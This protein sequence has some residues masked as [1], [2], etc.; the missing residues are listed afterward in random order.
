[1]ET[2][3]IERDDELPGLVTITLNRPEK[4]NAINARMHAEIQQ[5][6][7]D[8]ADDGDARVVIVTGAGRAFSAG[9]DLGGS[10][11]D[12]NR[13][14]LASANAER[15]PLR[16]R[17]RS[18]A[19]N[20][21]CAALEGLDQVTIGA[22]NGLAI[23]GAVVFLACLDIRVA[24]ESSWFSI[25]EVDLEIPLTWNALPRLMRELGPARTKELVMTCDRFSSEDALR[26]GFLNHRV[27]D[28]EILSRARDLAR[29][30]LD[31]DPVALALTKSTCNALAESMVPAHVTHSDRDYL[32]LSRL[33]AEER[34]RE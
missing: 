31:K 13:P 14:A 9:A 15:S 11:S 7:R 6:C 10:T 4:L 28:A 20:R 25:P 5:A 18:S 33:L 8:L 32:V 16:E 27:P 30:L 17:I 22:V 2:I 23:G 26:W 21:T 12:P 1:M 3:T 19:G 29:K 34:K 24:A